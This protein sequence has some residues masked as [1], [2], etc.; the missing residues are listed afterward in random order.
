MSRPPDPLGP[1]RTPIEVLGA[2]ASEFNETFVVGMRKRM[3]VSYHKYGLMA[4]AARKRVDQIESLRI[5]LERY[6]ET[7]NTEW[8]M[9][10]ANMAMI[11]F[12]HPLHPAAH[13]RPT[14]SDE[15]PGRVYES[16][17]VVPGKRVGATHNLDIP[18]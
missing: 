6:D 11:E 17:G 1:A 9:D 14:D 16:N 8:L 4:D 18:G 2:P 7:G 5:R 13:Y 15:S 10:V 3:A 12:T